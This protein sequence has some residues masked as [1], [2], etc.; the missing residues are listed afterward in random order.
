MD[1]LV[2]VELFDDILLTF[3]LDSVGATYERLKQTIFMILRK[4]VFPILLIMRTWIL[5]K[6]I[7]DTLSMDLYPSGVG[8]LILGRIREQSDNKWQV[9]ESNSCGFK[10]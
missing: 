10:C 6:K 4:L 5:K 2:V 3:G 1:G 9:L 8:M 7:K